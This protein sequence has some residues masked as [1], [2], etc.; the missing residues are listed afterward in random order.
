MVERKVYRFDLQKAKILSK[1]NPIKML[2]ILYKHY[3][4]NDI[5]LNGLSFL[6]NAKDFFL[7]KN[8]DILYRAQ[9]IDLAG[10]RSYQQYKD[11]NYTYLDLTYYPDININAITYNTLLIIKN[12]KIYFKYEE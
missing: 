8:V 11:L 4:R 9:Y 2:N 6:K 5:K 7:D 1:H 3:K 10:R 12:N